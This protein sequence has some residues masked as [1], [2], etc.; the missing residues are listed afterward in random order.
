MFVVDL[1]KRL[2]RGVR[3]LIKLLNIMIINEMIML[4]HY[5]TTLL[6]CYHTHYSYPKGEALKL[7]RHFNNLYGNSLTVLN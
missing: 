2:H 7:L 1:T 4:P 6:C 5:Y 3:I